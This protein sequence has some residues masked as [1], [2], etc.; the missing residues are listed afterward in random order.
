[1]ADCETSAGGAVGNCARK[2]AADPI[3]EVVKRIVADTGAIV[4][5]PGRGIA[6]TA[7]SSACALLTTHAATQTCAS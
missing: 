7:S 4:H 5:Q 2:A 1:M 6:E 3:E